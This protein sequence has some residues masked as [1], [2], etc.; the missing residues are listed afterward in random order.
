MI[1][2]NVLENYAIRL[3]YSVFPIIDKDG[4]QEDEQMGVIGF[5]DYR[6]QQSFLDL[7]N[8][9]SAYFADKQLFKKTEDGNYLVALGHPHE[10]IRSLIGLIER[11]DH[12]DFSIHGDLYYSGVLIMSNL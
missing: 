9:E 3:G 11:G 4:E 8:E 2:T 12:L 10:S 1:D 5:E 7:L 6:S